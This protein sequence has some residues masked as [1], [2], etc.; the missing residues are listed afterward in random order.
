MAPTLTLV[1]DVSRVQ[2]RRYRWLAAL[3]LLMVIELFLIQELTLTATHSQSVVDLVLDRVLRLVLDGLMVG[4]LVMLLPRKAL[5]V[6]FA[7]TLVYAFSVLAYFAYFERPLSGRIISAASGEGLSVV[8][9]AF[10]VLSAGHLLLVV[11]FAAKCW[12]VHRA[13]WRWRS[14]TRRHLAWGG[15]CI[16][17][18]LGLIA[19]LNLTYKPMEK[20]RTWETTA[21]IAQVYGYAP[22]WVAEVLL[23]QNDVLKERALDRA[24]EPVQNRLAAVEAPLPRAERVV[25]LQIESFDEA[26]MGFRL[27]GKPVV[28]E[29]ERI[30]AQSRRYRVASN[31]ITGSSDSDFKALMGRW[32]SI[33][34]PTYK[35]ADYPFKD[36]IIDDL[37]ARGYRTSAFH[38]VS[39]EF[40]NRRVGFT[41]MGFDELFF[42]EELEHAGVPSMGWSVLDDAV[43]DFAAAHLQGPGRQFA[44]V[45]T[46]TCH[47]PFH[48]VPE[49]ANTFFPGSHALAENYL[50]VSHYVD[51]GIG[52]FVDALPDGT[53]VVLYGDHTSKVEYPEVGYAQLEHDGIGLVPFLVWQ[54][55]AD[56]AKTQRAPSSLAESGELSL[57]EA[58]VWVHGQLLAEP[59]TQQ[60]AAATA[61]P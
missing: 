29:M 13:G 54:K 43:L 61:A 49:Q 16:A 53:L 22:T 3:V 52:R 15:G 60:H 14:R 26:L 24:E 34:V 32:P 12:L 5:P 6:F 41:G 42:R 19:L 48:H 9:A 57:L 28:P 30:A 7:T 58:L 50:D 38:G 47:I 21:G 51:E 33:D 20:L 10:A 1:S 8:D 11:A 4:A 27:D 36:S 56:L 37:Q 44:I 55:G 25:F 31:K 2:S 45:I 23:F 59:P 39:G 40:F 35:I 46:A 17:L 18:Y